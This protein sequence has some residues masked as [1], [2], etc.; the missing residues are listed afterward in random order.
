MRAFGIFQLANQFETSKE[1]LS[2]DQNINTNFRSGGP[3]KSGG[4]GLQPLNP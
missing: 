1:F 2:F 4:S 3:F